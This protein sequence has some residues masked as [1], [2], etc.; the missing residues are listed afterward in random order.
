MIFVGRN[1]TKP[2]SDEIYVK[3]CATLREAEDFIDWIENNIDREGVKRGE[4][5][6]DV[7][8]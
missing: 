7:P 6:I 4:Y 1:D 2:I 3:K 5:Y 8:Q